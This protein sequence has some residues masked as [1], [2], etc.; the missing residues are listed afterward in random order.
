[1]AGDELGQLRNQVNQLRVQQQQG[2]V[3]VYI[4]DGRTYEQ[5]QIDLENDLKRE[6]RARELHEMQMKE[7]EMRL[8]SVAEE[9]NKKVV[10]EFDAIYSRLKGRVSDAE[11]SETLL[12][13]YR[14]NSFFLKN[15]S[16]TF[17]MLSGSDAVRLYNFVRE[18]AQS[19]TAGTENFF[20]EQKV[21]KEAVKSLK[22][23]LAK[24]TQDAS[25]QQNSQSP[26]RVSNLQTPS[27]V[28]ESPYKASPPQATTPENGTYS[29]QSTTADPPSQGGEWYQCLSDFQVGD[30]S[31]KEGQ[32]IVAYQEQNGIVYFPFMEHKKY[33][34][35]AQNVRLHQAQ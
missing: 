6:G 28:P 29:S 25:T 33:T 32:L 19:V 1:M 8:Q 22:E 23:L 30:L 13:V 7:R 31:F 9:Q 20:Q 2:P 18:D 14:N 27:P 11:I 10:D 3:D 21:K 34:L 12:N 24:C 5:K 16:Q 35:P 15:I 26:Y 4:R 17:P